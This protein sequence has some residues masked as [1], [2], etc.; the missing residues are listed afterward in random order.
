MS[1]QDTAHLEGYQEGVEVGI[2]KGIE[3]GK[4]MGL[5]E[6]ALKKARDRA[7]QLLSLKLLTPEQIAQ[8]A[9][10]SLDEVLKLSS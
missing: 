5:E 7:Q 3:V 8:M 4:Q 9:G 10:L 2:E 1:A 6:G